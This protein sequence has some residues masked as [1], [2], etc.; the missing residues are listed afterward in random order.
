MKEAR[1][2]RIPRVPF[3]LNQ[4]KQT[5]I[6]M[7][8]FAYVGGKIVKKNQDVLVVPC[9]IQVGVKLRRAGGI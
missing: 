6:T 9:V 7:F 5:N 3:Y 1:L 2:Q 4:V 8:G